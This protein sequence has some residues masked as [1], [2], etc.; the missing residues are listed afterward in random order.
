MWQ[1]VVGG[2]WDWGWCAGM[3]GTSGGLLRAERTGS[4]NDPVPAEASPQHGRQLC[5]SGQRQRRVPYSAHLA[6]IRKWEALLAC[7]TAAAPPGR[8]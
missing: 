1:G 7:R 2:G 4:K 5:L 3:V 8:C 6:P